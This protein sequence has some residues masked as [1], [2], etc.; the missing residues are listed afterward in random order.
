MVGRKHDIPVNAPLTQPW[1]SRWAQSPKTQ[2]GLP[3][4]TFV[5]SDFLVGCLAALALPL[6]AETRAL[7]RGSAGVRDDARGV[8]KCAEAAHSR[9]GSA[10]SLRRLPAAIPAR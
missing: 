5:G 2:V 4:G 8:R 1:K 10:S 6:Y 3:L 7:S 9:S